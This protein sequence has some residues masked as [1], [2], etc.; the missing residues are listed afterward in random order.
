[1]A[2]EHARSEKVLTTG[3][4][5]SIRLPTT[6]IGPRLRLPE[7]PKVRLL[8]AGKNRASDGKPSPPSCGFGTLLW[9]LACLYGPGI[10]GKRGRSLGWNRLMPTAE[11]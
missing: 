11:V 5:W 8:I 10:G 9:L 4:D 6:A 3:V 1:M 7:Q 2:P